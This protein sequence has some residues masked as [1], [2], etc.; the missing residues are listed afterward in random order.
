MTD[1]PART[2]APIAAI[3][4]IID[5]FADLGIDPS[6]LH[7]AGSR[8]LDPRPVINVWTHTR[9]DFERVV[10]RLGLKAVER[11]TRPGQREWNAERDTETLR[12]L[13]TCVSFPH[14]A[15]WREAE[16]DG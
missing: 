9:T 4:D 3:K 7:T 10:E 13:I 1:T 16:V 5:T 8:P 12:L 14:H 11:L 2:M 15:D 6:V